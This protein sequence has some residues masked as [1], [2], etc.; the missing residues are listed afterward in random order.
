MHCYYNPVCVS[1][2]LPTHLVGNCWTG[3]IC[4]SLEIAHAWLGSECQPAA[5][6]QPESS[7]P[8]PHLKQTSTKYYYLVTQIT[9]TSTQINNND[10]QQE[11]SDLCRLYGAGCV[12]QKRCLQ[13]QQRTLLRVEGTSSA[14]RPASPLSLVISHT[15]RFKVKKVFYSFY[16]ILIIS[17]YIKIMT[18]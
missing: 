1:P 2:K 14:G 5:S 15:K 8:H 11:V 13:S 10:E 3:R 7:A 9:F 6:P 18:Q 16:D 12:V 17:Y 4:Q